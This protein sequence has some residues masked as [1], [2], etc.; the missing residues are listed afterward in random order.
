MPL[1]SSETL[2]ERNKEYAKSHSPLPTITEAMAGGDD[3]KRTIVVTC[4]DNRVSPDVL[5]QTTPLDGIIICRNAGGRVAKALPDIMAL[6]TLLKIQSIMVIHHTDCGASHFTNESVRKAHENGGSNHSDLENMDF[7]AFTDVEQSIRDDLKF[8]KDSSYIP[9]AVAE[10]STGYV[11]DIKTG[12][13]SLVNE[14]RI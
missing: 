4:A 2:L 13:L 8:L 14:S 12:L 3:F 6:G 11:Y 9:K 10:R 1:A 5:L 7:G